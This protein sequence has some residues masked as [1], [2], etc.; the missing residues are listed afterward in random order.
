MDDMGRLER[1]R[2]KNGV[3]HLSGVPA[4]AT[5]TAIMHTLKAV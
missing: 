3:L 1:F 4:V 5:E 2:V